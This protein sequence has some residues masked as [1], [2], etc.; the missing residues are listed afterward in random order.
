MQSQT[1]ITKYNIILTKQIWTDIIYYL[2]ELKME[3]NNF[4][5]KKFSKLIKYQNLIIVQSHINKLFYL[6]WKFP[7]EYYKNLLK[8]MKYWIKHEV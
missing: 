8:P 7:I 3:Y 2:F 5:L 1:D 6:K 4:D